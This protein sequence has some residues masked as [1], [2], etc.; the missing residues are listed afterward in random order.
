MKHN[1][2]INKLLFKK[3]DRVTYNHEREMILEIYKLF[4]DNYK[5]TGNIVDEIDSVYLN[6]SYS[7]VNMFSKL[8]NNIVNASYYL[9]QMADT[10]YIF[11][12]VLEYNYDFLLTDISYNV[13]KLLKKYSKKRCMNIIL[14]TTCKCAKNIYLT[15]NRLITIRDQ[16]IDKDIFVLNFTNKI[17]S[18]VE[19][20]INNYSD[21]KRN[22]DYLFEMMKKY[23]KGLFSRFIDNIKFKYKT[24]IKPFINWLIFDETRLNT[25]SSFVN[26]NFFW[27]E[28]YD[29]GIDSV[30][31]AL[32]K[33][34]SEPIVNL[35]M[36]YDYKPFEQRFSKEVQEIFKKT[37]A[38]D[39][40]REES[41]LYIKELNN[42]GQDVKK[43]LNNICNKMRKSI[44]EFDR[45]IGDVC[46]S[47]LIYSS[48][49][50]YI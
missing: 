7:K 20:Y 32:K 23:N 3:Y 2:R 18:I 10:I 49:V 34:N 30:N 46:S 31:Y 12:K 38:L 26:E 36:K 11:D 14:F 13:D 41:L 43:D 16:Y 44:L 24:C 40:T 22:Y 17:I 6:K 39:I 5:N 19:K 25:S 15:Y 28:R 29:N 33:V 35:M 21:C 37:S 4:V 1:N 42:L 27:G 48:L 47:I 50:N 45:F 9:I 8:P